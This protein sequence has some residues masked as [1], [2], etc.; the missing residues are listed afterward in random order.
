MDNNKIY[1]FI[2]N[3]NYI[4]EN[5]I[6][7]FSNLGYKSLFPE[8]EE[9]FFKTVKKNLEMLVQN[10]LTESHFIPLWTKNI[11]LN[12]FKTFE[13]PIL[14]PKPVDLKNNLA[15]IV[16][17]GPNLI[18]D[19][20]ELKINRE[21]VT[22]FCVDTALKTLLANDVIPDFVVSLDSQYYSLDDFVN[23]NLD[24]VYFIFDLSGYPNI[25]KLYKNIFFTTTD[26]IFEKSI[27]E[28]SF[29]KI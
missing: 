6:S 4:T 14:N 10:T 28:Y 1:N 16:S 26:N 22:V 24:E 21:R 17:A 3:N 11:L 25:T 15:V 12:L 5:R 27:I 23:R 29:N 7:F 18:F 13:Q 2:S 9:S 20:P 19:I 8:A